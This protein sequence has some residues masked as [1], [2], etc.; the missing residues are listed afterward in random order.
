MLNHKQDSNADW[1]FDS[2]DGSVWV[3][4][5]DDAMVSQF[6]ASEVFVWPFFQVNF[7]NFWYATLGW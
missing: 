3:R 5:T 6:F 7:S 4:A 2:S 1:D